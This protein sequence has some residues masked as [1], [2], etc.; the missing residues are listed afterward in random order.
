[1]IDTGTDPAA[2]QPDETAYPTFMVSGNNPMIHS[3]PDKGKMMIRHQVLSRTKG[4]RNGKPH[5]SIHIQVKGVEPMVNHKKNGG[6]DDDE[7]AMGAMMM[8]G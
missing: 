8:N 5:H 3:I 6:G 4:I 2:G 7:A 1:M